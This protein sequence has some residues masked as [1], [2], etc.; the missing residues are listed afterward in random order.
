MRRL[1]PCRRAAGSDLPRRRPCLLRSAD[2]PLSRSSL[3][4]ESPPEHL[5]QGQ[6]REVERVEL[7]HL[8]HLLERLA[9]PP[10]TEEE[11][12]ELEMQ[13][14]RTLP[15]LGAVLERRAEEQLRLLGVF[16][17]ESL[18]GLHLEQDLF[19]RLPTHR[20]LTSVRWRGL[21]CPATHRFQ[22]L[23]HANAFPVTP[24]SGAGTPTPAASASA[25][26]AHPTSPCARATRANASQASRA[27][28]NS[29]ATASASARARSSCAVATAN[30]T[31]ARCASRSAS[32]ASTSRVYRRGIASSSSARAGSTSAARSRTATSWNA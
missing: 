16:R 20:P 30:R 27:A 28:G 8:D 26:A 6:G 31:I 22:L 25:A 4:L 5:A 2:A 13:R 14:G 17:G 15:D 11:L 7:E 19:D 23:V 12:R 9:G 18:R 32:P 3:G 1:Q 24:N 21:P 29:V 10:E